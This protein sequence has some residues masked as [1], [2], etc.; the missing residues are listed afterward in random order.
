ME[1][2]ITKPYLVF[3]AAP[4]SGLFS[5]KQ[6][7]FR[8]ITNFLLSTE[9]V[10]ASP[11]DD[12]VKAEDEVDERPQTECDFCQCRRAEINRLLE[13][14]RALKHELDRRKMNEQFLKGDN[15]KVKYYTGLPDFE[16]VMGVLACV[17]PY[18]TQGSKMLS[19]FQMLFLTLI[20]LRLNLPTQHIAHLFHVDRKTVSK[21]FG[22]IINVL[23]A[24]ISPNCP[25]QDAL[26]VE[27]TGEV[28]RARPHRES[29][30]GVIGAIR[31]KYTMLSAKVP[32]RTLLNTKDE[33]QTFHDKVVSVCC[34]LTNMSPG[35]VLKE[36][37][38]DE[39]Y[40]IDPTL[41]K[42]S[43]TEKHE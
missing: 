40:F 17:G 25:V 15:V 19:P 8:T 37:E 11:E 16:A 36:E 13:E 29:V 9:E 3:V 23:H 31:N 6:M 18:L 28:A 12:R 27:S 1:P 34:A 2:A 26:H 30:D 5:P 33:D 41:D 35:V 4:V 21:T 43:E 14:N 38:K 22:D 42:F 32:V 20:R 39:E 10:P 24:R 7:S